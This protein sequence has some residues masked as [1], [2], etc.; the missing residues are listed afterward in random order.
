[1]SFNRKELIYFSLS[2]FLF[3]F[4]CS[5]FV[6]LSSPILFPRQNLNCFMKHFTWKKLSFLK[7]KSL[8]S[9]SFNLHA[10]S[11]RQ[12]IIN[13]I[14]GTGQ[15]STAFDFTTKG[16]LQVYSRGSL[17]TQGLFSFQEEL[18]FLN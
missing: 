1:M 8:L 3:V 6:E 4:S 15:L 5:E 11:H 18:I 14:N 12:R 9:L 7:K 2:S 16:I 17:Y 10:D 13:W